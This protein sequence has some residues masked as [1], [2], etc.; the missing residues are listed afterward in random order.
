MGLSCIVRRAPFGGEF[1]IVRA[2]GNAF[3]RLDGPGVREQAEK[4]G[5]SAKMGTHSVRKGAAGAIL[6]PGGAFAQMLKRWSVAFGGT[7]TIA[8][9][10]GQ[11]R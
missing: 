10:L 6:E 8:G 4:S 9:P 11:S 7:Q 1:A 5:A 3:P 2:R